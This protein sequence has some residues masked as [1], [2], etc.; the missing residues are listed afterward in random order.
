MNDPDCRARLE[1]RYTEAG[2]MIGNQV[3]SF[4]AYSDNFQKRPPR[5]VESP[6][7]GTEATGKP[8][9]AAGTSSGGVSDQHSVQALTSATT[10]RDERPPAQ[11][12]R[13]WKLAALLTLDAV[14]AGA[15]FLLVRS[16]VDARNFAAA[17]R[18]DP[19][20]GELQAGQALLISAAIGTL[21]GGILAVVYR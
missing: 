5:V 15:G 2:R 19:P 17:H 21:V 16:S 1:H 14:A 20:N 6:N 4:L 7:A 18:L 10:L 13:R 9:A 8:A 3:G 12:P 11:R